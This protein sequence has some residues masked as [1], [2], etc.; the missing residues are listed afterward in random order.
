M[1]ADTKLGTEQLL[2]TT[3]WVCVCM[4]IYMFL[5]TMYDY[6][7]FVKNYPYRKDP[8]NGGRAAE[9]KRDEHRSRE[10]RGVHEISRRVQLLKSKGITAASGPNYYTCRGS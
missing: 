2:I 6:M 5:Q 10:G 4:N 1:D 3:G 7:H 8:G 9:E